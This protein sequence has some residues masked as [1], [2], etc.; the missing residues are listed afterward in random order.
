MFSSNP[1]KIIG[2]TD[3]VTVGGDPVEANGDDVFINI[4]SR[5]SATRSIQY[6]AVTNTDTVIKYTFSVYKD[7]S[8]LDWFTNDSTGVDAE[9]FMITGYL[10]GGD[11]QRQKQILYITTYL[12]KTEDGFTA[13]V[14]GDFVP[15]NQSSCL[16]QAQWNWANSANSNKWGKTF[17]AY[18]HRRVYWPVDI[19]DTFDDG[20]SV[21][22]TRNKLRG[23]GRVLSIKFSTEPGKDLHLYGWSM[24][25]AATSSV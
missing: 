19:D 4:S 15:T 24:I 9:A 16:I 10:S 8:W 20:N 3:I 2:G 14:N 7:E 12:R 21:V 22:V 13:D 18:R 17:Q 25:L 23:K 11:F 1:Y 5:T 6:V